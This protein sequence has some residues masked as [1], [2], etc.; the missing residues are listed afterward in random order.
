MLFST[1][2]CAAGSTSC[3]FI[4]NHATEVV[5][6]LIN[7]LSLA[8]CTL[9]EAFQYNKSRSE[10]SFNLTQQHLSLTIFDRTLQLPLVQV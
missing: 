6:A 3:S 10:L 9:A 1:F 5:H 4:A 2:S 8:M 7:L